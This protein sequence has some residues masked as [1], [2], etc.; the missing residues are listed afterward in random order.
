M[1]RSNAE[2]PVHSYLDREDFFFLYSSTFYDGVLA[3]QLRSHQMFGVDRLTVRTQR[4]VTQTPPDK[5]PLTP[6]FE[7][8]NALR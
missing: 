3:V 6:P 4:A 8:T 1:D 5:R 7:G 2:A